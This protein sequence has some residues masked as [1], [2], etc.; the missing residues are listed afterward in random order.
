M[1][2]FMLKLRLKEARSELANAIDQKEI[3]RLNRD[4]EHLKSAIW[5]VE[6]IEFEERVGFKSMEQNAGVWDE[7]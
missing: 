6:M 7:R 3:D 1:S 2:S 4:I 5:E